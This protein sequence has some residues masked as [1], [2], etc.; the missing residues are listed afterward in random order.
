MKPVLRVVHNNH[1]DLTWRRC[2]WRRFTDQ[3]RR[4]ASYAEIQEWYVA[5]HLE[6][7]DQ[8]PGW[9]FDIESPAVARTVL[10]RRPEWR[11][12]LRALAA[13]GRLGLSCTGDN[14]IDGNMVHGESLVRNFTLGLAWTARELGLHPRQAARHDAFGNPCQLPQILRG[15][16]QDWVLGLS[17]SGVGKARYWRGLDGSVVCTANPEWVATGGGVHKMAPCPQCHGTGCAA[18]AG[19]GVDPATTLAEIPDRLDHTRAADGRGCVRIGPEEALPHA[20]LR[21]W[22]G[23]L[24]ERYAVRCVRE[25]DLRELVADDLARVDDPPAEAVFPGPELN[26]NNTGTFTTRIGLKQRARAGEAALRLAETVAALSPAWPA[27]RIEDLW[28]RLL[29]TLFHDSITGTTVD[30]AADELTEVQHGLLAD[31]ALLRDRLLGGDP[32]APAWTAINPLGH[33]AAALVELPDD[34]ATV[35]AGPAGPLPTVP[36]PDGRVRVLATVP[37]LGTAVL[38]RVPGVRTVRALAEPVIANR[39]FRIRA[40]ARGILAVEDLALGRTI[41]GRRGDLDPAGLAIE[42]DIGSPWA[43]LVPPGPTKALG[44]HTRLVAAEAGD[45]WQRLRLAMDGGIGRFAGFGSG[46]QTLR[47][48]QEVLLVDGLDRIEIRTVVDWDTEGLRLRLGWPVPMAGRGV[49][50]VPYGRIE[51]APYEPVHAWAGSCGDWPALG[52]SALVGADAAVALLDRGTPGHRVDPEGTLWASLLRSPILGTYLHEPEYYTMT[53]YDGMRD[54][55]TH[56]FAHAVTAAVSVDDGILAQADAFGAD[57]GPAPGA[58]TLGPAPAVAGATLGAVTRS[59]DG[60]LLL[61][62]VERHGRPGSAVVTLPAGATRAWSAD[63]RGRERTPLA[64]TD[65]R[66]ALPLEPW[67]IATVVIG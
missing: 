27:A 33:P 52:W 28:Q 44:P 50:G 7:C 55:G 39:R 18:C 46:G 64:V 10:A 24:G 63:L 19:R 22:L 45:G 38:R 47:A 61:R 16:G 51:R 62:I 15:V 58:R 57:L 37:A 4:F 34:P 14:I 40:D 11:D 26:P 1:F 25:E 30:A 12:R 36:G 43:R 35:V 8:D 67:R 56:V 23:G 2:A 13:A 29:F 59:D 3:G 42:T 65:G 9:R 20:G 21:A 41:G 53:A 31:A 17:Y 48:E 6:L 66:F 54:A 5:A 49:Y 60:L 32:R